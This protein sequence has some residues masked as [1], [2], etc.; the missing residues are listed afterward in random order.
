MVLQLNH[1]Q[2]PDVRKYMIDE[3]EFDK[4]N[5]NFYFS[6]RLQTIKH[7]VYIDLLRQALKE[8]NDESLASEIERNS[9]LIQQETRQ[10]KYGPKIANLPYNAHVVL[11][12][13]EFNRYYIR[14][15]CRKAQENVKQLEVY[16]AKQ[17]SSPRPESQAKIGKT[18]DPTQLLNDLR[19]DS[20]LCEKNHGGWVDN[21]L[22]IPAGPNSGLSVRIKN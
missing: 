20:K 6:N 14:G 11:A 18:I 8:G 15:V 3:L 4:T 5:N 22:G 16:R 2:E 13:A 7:S 12:E 10:T 9:C 21:A 19:K 17:V 1:L